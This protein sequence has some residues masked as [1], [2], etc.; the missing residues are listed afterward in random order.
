MAKSPTDERQLH[1]GINQDRKCRDFI[2]IIIFA[3]FWA[4]MFVVCSTAVSNGA[5]YT[6]VYVLF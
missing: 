4:G 2:F 5:P 6:L 1:G 3:I